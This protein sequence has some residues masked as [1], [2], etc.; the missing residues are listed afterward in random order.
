MT[1]MVRCDNA[2]TV[3]WTSKREWTIWDGTG[4]AEQPHRLWTGRR[5]RQFL[6]RRA[7]AGHVRD[8]GDQPRAV[9]RR[10][11][12]RAPVAADYATGALDRD[13]QSLSR[14]HA[15]DPARSGRGG[16]HRWRIAGHAARSAQDLRDDSA[17]A[18]PRIDGER[19]H[20]P[21]S[22]SVDRI[23]RWRAHDRSG[24]RG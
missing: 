12:R 3:K 24:R 14:A 1:W 9:A 8:H 11:A 20:A 10:S 15:P 22:R 13:R 23:D 18:V 4:S 21:P 5:M 16:S 7:A 2:D 19:V 6:R 17:G